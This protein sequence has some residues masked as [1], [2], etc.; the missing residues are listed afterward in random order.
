MS[1]L[2]RQPSLA[3]V[4]LYVS[5]HGESLGENGIYAGQT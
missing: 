2:E 5:D 1:E 3:T 4:L